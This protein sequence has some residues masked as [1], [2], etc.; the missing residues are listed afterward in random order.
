MPASNYE[1]LIAGQR[2]P[3]SFLAGSTS[4]LLEARGFTL[5]AITLIDL[6]DVGKPIQRIRPME[7]TDTAQQRPFQVI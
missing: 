5:S 6:G 2:C 4:R 3:A 7:T 1:T